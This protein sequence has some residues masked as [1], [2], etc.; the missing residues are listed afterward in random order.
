MIIGVP[1]EIKDQEGRVALLPEA[2]SS[3][4]KAGHH[5]LVQRGAGKES[6]YSDADY[7][8]AGAK[9]IPTALVLYKNSEL[10]VKVKEPLPAEYPFFRKDLRIFC[11]L[12][13]AANPGLTRRLMKSGVCALAFETL[14]DAAGKVPLL[15][16]MSE[17]AGRLSVTL[18]AHYLQK[19][20]GG[21]GVLL[22]PTH[23]SEPGNVVVIG[24]GN[25]GRAAAEVAVGLGARV[26]VLDIRVESLRDWASFYSQMQLL[27]STPQNIMAALQQADLVVGAIYVLGAKTPKVISK[28]MVQSMPKGSVL[29]DVAVDQGGTSETTRPT[30]ISNPTYVRFGVIHCAVTNMPALVSRTSSQAL[31]R[32]ILPYVE[33][34]ANHSIDQYYH[35]PELATALNVCGGKIVHP[36][37]KASL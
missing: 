32:T 37:V 31:S 15:K 9:I 25:V 12:H 4:V 10:V 17:I 21:R 13:L 36:K 23:V 18:G 3:L 30:S 34:V 5:V 8:Q 14:E 19:N 35:D 33:K 22:S 28:A 16:P 7:L 1:K 24:G 27:P 2:V 11:F 26:T 20:H 29:M 6:G